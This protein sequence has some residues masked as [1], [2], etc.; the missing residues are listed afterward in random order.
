MA[1]ELIISLNNF[2][3]FADT[4]PVRIAPL[5][6]LVGENST[7]KTSFLAALRLALNLG[8]KAKSG[9]FNVYPFD[10]GS[11]EDIVHDSGTKAT[12]HRFSM[13]IEKQVDI[14]SEGSILIRQ[15]QKS[16]I[17]KAKLK[18]IFKSNFGEVSISSFDFS[19]EEIEIKYE[20]NPKP[21]FTLFL[22]GRPVR[23]EGAH[24]ETLFREFADVKAA[25]LRRLSYALYDRYF[26]WRSHSRKGRDHRPAFERAA[27]AFDA[28]ISAGHSL[29]TSPPV[30]S[31]PRRVY[32][33]SDDIN[34]PDVSHAPYQLNRL[35]RADRRRWTRL[36]TGLNLFGKLSG[37]FTRFD[38]TKLTSQDSGPFQ[39]KVTVRGRSSN[40]ADVGYGVS[41]ALP[42]MTD[43]IEGGSGRSAFLFQQ[44]EV[45]LHPKA[46][47]ALGTIFSEHISEHSNSFIIAETHS[48]Y[49]I[50]RVRIEVRNKR[51]S[52]G[53]INILYFD[54]SEK[55]VK[56]HEITLDQEGNLLG[57]P[58]RYREFFRQLYTLL[59][60]ASVRYRLGRRVGCHFKPM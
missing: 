8:E 43:L 15:T 7:G 27:R 57:A 31:V 29:Y 16:D 25:D 42:L 46:Q 3:A 6:L 33:S 13:T 26:G 11:Y 58:P 22:G 35:K 55:D 52:P 51:L 45:H 2:R 49:L 14:A 38:I 40:I 32:T 12:A 19:F 20:S 56:I 41:Q 1:K 10:L 54:A 50:D 39:L 36:N 23:D 48:D 9:Y 18:I 37:L 59:S 60:T 28:F 24:Q 5:T 47:A 30:R 44:P 17:V 53:L 4:G 34:S 21:I